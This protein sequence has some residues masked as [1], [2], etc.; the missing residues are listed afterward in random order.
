VPVLLEH[1]ALQQHLA[2]D[3]TL[4]IDVLVTS[5]KDAGA[6][7]A[8]ALRCDPDTAASNGSICWWHGTGFGL[9]SSPAAGKHPF[10]K[11][12]SHLFT[13][14]NRGKP[15]AQSALSA[16]L[17]ELI[18]PHLVV[19]RWHRIRAS[20]P[21]AAFQPPDLPLSR[22]AAGTSLSFLT[23]SLGGLRTHLSTDTSGPLDLVQ[24]HTDVLRLLTQ[25]RPEGYGAGQGAVGFFRAV[26]LAALGV[27][28]ALADVLRM[29]PGGNDCDWPSSMWAIRYLPLL[30]APRFPF[31]L[32]EHLNEGLGWLREHEGKLVW[33]RNTGQ[34][35]EGAGALR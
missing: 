25:L 34:Y 19:A 13:Y 1:Y 5:R 29:S 4:A 35:T 10:T 32:P 8:A 27:T 6:L 33:D 3:P 12:A 26:G 30:L 17:T 20:Y 21:A 28:A 15:E 16:R 9:G 14:A 24:S 7:A 22:I 31:A 2:A 18:E 23:L 11:E